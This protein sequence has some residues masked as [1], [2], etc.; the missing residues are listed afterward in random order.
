MKT[1][2]IHPELRRAIVEWL[3][4]NE[5]VFNRVNA[6][7]DNFRQYIYD[8]AGNYAIGGKDVHDYILTMSDELFR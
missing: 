5:S 4:N 1:R 2:T 7:V 3:F 6:C 8:A